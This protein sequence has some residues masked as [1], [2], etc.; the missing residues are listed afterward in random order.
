M[1]KICLI[2]VTLVLALA[3][4]GSVLAQGKTQTVCPVLKGNVDKNV[5]VDYKG[6]RIYFCCKGCDAE[7]QKDPEKYLKKMESQGVTLEKSPA[8]AS[9]G[10][11]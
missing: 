4:A 5:Y 11:K 6:H 3:L 9:K 10:G 8:A 2:L 1:K 7:F